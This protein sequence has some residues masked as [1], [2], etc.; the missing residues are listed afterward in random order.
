M[1]KALTS[2]ETQ[3]EEIGGK[4]S[5]RCE[6]IKQNLRNKPESAKFTDLKQRKKE[7]KVHR[8]ITILFY[9]T[10]SESCIHFY[11]Q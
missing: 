8:D 1:E 11:S 5:K 2:T 7:F 10:T 9:L 3:V 6:V 4:L